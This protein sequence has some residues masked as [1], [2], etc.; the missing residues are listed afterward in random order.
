MMRK[1][2]NIKKY[3]VHTDKTFLKYDTANGCQKGQTE[4]QPKGR[5]N[6]K[7]RKAGENILSKPPTDVSRDRQKNRQRAEEIT[8]RGRQEKIF[9]PSHQRTSE[10]TDRK[11]DRGQMEF[12]KEDSSRKY[13]VQ[14]TDGRQKGQTEKQT[15]G[16]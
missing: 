10:G 2:L 5:C 15:E 4:K 13:F 14:A 12:Q 16:R 8:K 9:C 7:K 6:F 1:L 11:T 3:P